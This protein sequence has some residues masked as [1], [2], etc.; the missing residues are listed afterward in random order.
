MKKFVLAA[1]TFLIFA[2]PAL[3][4]DGLFV[5]A[6]QP[7]E[8]LAG[9]S[10]FFDVTIDNKVEEADWYSL[11]IYPS[12]WVSIE[13][14]TSALFLGAYDKKTF[15]VNVNPPVDA[16]G[17][18]YIYSVSANGRKLGASTGVIVPVKQ[19]YRSLLLTDFSVSCSE[20]SD[21]IELTAKVKNVGNIEIENLN[22]LISAGQYSKSVGLEKLEQGEEKT[23]SVKFL[24]GSWSPGNYDASVKLTSNAGSDNKRAQFSVPVQSRIISTKYSQKNFLGSTVYLIVKNEGNV[25][26]TTDVLSEKISD[27]FVAVY[28]V[29]RP[30]SATGGILTWYATLAPGEQ[31]TY[32]YSQV[33]WPIPLG[34]FLVVLG[35]AYAYVIATAI[36]IRKAIFGKAGVFGV[37]LQVKNRGPAT[38]G[39][40]VKD[41]V[42]AT[43]S[44]IPS[45]ETLKPIMRRVAEG[46]E[47]I[48]R[49][50]TV[51]KGEERVLHYK[52]KPVGPASGALPK[53]VLRGRRGM[54][55]LQKTSNFVPVPHVPGARE[56]KLKVVVEE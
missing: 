19:R 39:V 28:P 10:T 41:V 5:T 51:G 16:R 38:D 53:A 25:Q 1:L 2:A 6:T 21:F 11:S 14:G 54:S 37:S 15:R 29:D 44:V 18:N 45:F 47:L 35:A 55:Y 46:T 9:E 49:V 3:A 8:V 12:D 50:G 32:V 17:I 7:S 34:G 48:W 26:S 56:Q 43:F 36:E 27:P 33:F 30:S 40:V 20:C 42:P 31:R 23:V 4:E 52:I 24:V 22:F 13:G